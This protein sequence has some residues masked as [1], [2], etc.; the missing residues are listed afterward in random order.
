MSGLPA[1]IGAGQARGRRRQEAAASGSII[2]GGFCL[3]E[4]DPAARGFAGCIAS[5]SARSLP[6]AKP[7]VALFGCGLQDALV[8]FLR[9]EPF[10]PGA[11]V[12]QAIPDELSSLYICHR[13]NKLLASLVGV[14]RERLL[15]S[16]QFSG[17]R[18]SACTAL[19]HRP[20]G[21][22]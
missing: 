6:S 13:P 15:L 17:G 4:A 18:T 12:C 2:S 14:W 16:P 10:S 7:I 8:G 11:L 3:A 21:N 9:E 5:C 1:L 20:I 19:R 22:E